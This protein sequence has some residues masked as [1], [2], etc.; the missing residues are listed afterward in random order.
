MPLM[1]PNL[2]DLRFQKDLVDEAR[3]R[4]IR[5]CPEWTDYNLSDPGITLIELFAYMTEMLVYRLNRVPEKNYLQFLDMLGM[6][7]LPA[8][9]ART[10]LTFYLSVPFPINP[11]DEIQANVPKGLEI[12]TRP[13]EE[14]EEITFTVDERLSILP[15]KLVQLRREAEF[16]KNYLRNLG[17]ESFYAF[18]QV[19]PKVGDT[20]FV[21]LDSAQDLRG[22]IL[23]LTFDCVE[24]QAV[25]VKRDDPPLVWECSLGGNRWKKIPLSERRGERDTTGGLNNAHGALVLHLPLEFQPD[26]VHGQT[27]FWLRCRLE[28]TSEDQGVY[29]E[30]P[31]INR[32]QVHAL[33]AKTWATHAI[34]VHDE[35]LGSSNGEP[36][37]VLHLQNAPV[38]AL[39]EEDKVE[40]EERRGSE[41]V[42]IPWT[43][44]TDFSQSDSFERHFMLNEVNGEV[45]FGPAIRQPDG[46]IKQYGRVP[47][48][49]RRVRV[50]QYRYG[51]GVLG[52]VP[53]ERIQVLRSSVPY[54]DRVSNF[55]RAEGGRDQESLDEVKVRAQRELRAQQRAVT[56][57]DFEN[58]AKN[59]SRE[60][61]RVKCN[62]AARGGQGLAPGVIELLVVPAAFDSL[63]VGKLDKLTLHPDLQCE[64]RDYLDQYRLL[65]TIMNIRE[66]KYIGVKVTAEI[67]IAE[68]SQPEV[69]KARV[70]DRLKR[71]LSPL[72]IG[73]VEER[74]EA[75]GPDWEGWPFGRDLYV[76]ELYSMIQRVAGVRHVLDVRI[77]CRP[78]LL[79]ESGADISG[80]DPDEAL[81]PVAERML[82]VEADT[83][84]CSLQHEITVV[85]L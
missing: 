68:F 29:S 62:G 74:A 14:E 73:P 42:F 2:D 65:A 3:R 22:Y 81:T 51:G 40:I 13:S 44:V 79:G 41:V 8:S 34:I 82:P 71:Y 61:A 35:I 20:F 38:L 50:S 45:V 70:Q 52:N 31:R 11:D 57:E 18:N 10:E 64:I 36:G 23:R 7:P 83:L 37:Q 63:E 48:A 33:G 66:P 55:E 78:I 17:I 75:F 4:I 30:S 47:E 85:E 25:G 43:R 49:G 80:D 16:N 69:V 56:A 84:V 59:A 27:A 19:K 5:Y 53:A 12:T 32:L 1:S 72:A 24:N 60:V 67:A 15:P 58:L 6:N 21:G 76:A 9:S 46:S 77:S 28:P 54:I 26:L 39:R